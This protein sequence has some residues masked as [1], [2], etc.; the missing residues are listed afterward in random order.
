[1]QDDLNVTALPIAHLLLL[2][3]TLIALARRTGI[4]DLYLLL[5]ALIA[6]LLAISVLITLLVW[7]RIFVIATIVCVFTAAGIRWR[8]RSNDGAYHNRNDS[9]GG[10]KADGGGDG[11]DE[12]QE[13]NEEVVEHG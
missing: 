2:I 3:Q 8:S 9:S 12:P 7:L 11:D 13:M 4:Q 10:G 5:F 6:A 1:M